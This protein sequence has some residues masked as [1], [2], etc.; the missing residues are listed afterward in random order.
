MKGALKN[1]ALK[2]HFCTINSSTL[3]HSDNYLVFLSR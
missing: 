2:I 1:D 3:L